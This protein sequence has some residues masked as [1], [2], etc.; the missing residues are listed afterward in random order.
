M[1]YQCSCCN[2][3]HSQRVITDPATDSPSDG[4]SGEPSKAG[5][6]PDTAADDNDGFS[7]EDDHKLQAMKKENKT[8]AVI[9]AEMRRPKKDLQNRLKK[10]E[11]AVGDSK[12]EE[13]KEGD[14]AK[15]GNGQKGEDGGKKNK[16]KSE[17]NSAKE[18]KAKKAR[19]EGLKRKAEKEGKKE[20]DAKKDSKAE[21]PA[22]VVEATKVCEAP[23]D[24]RLLTIRSQQ[25][26]MSTTSRNGLQLLRNTLTIQAIASHL[27]RLE[28]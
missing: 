16:E 13:K 22:T 11:K 10:L 14:D 8:W 6:K 23:A 5:E 18:E 15:G 3:F 25:P 17:K 1:F 27:N 12:P 21:I 26:S 9:I 20:E 7:A 28:N 19:E 24:R 2:E 4:K